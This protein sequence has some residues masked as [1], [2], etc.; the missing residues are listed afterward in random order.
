M[1]DD[2]ELRAARYD[3][4]R[5]HLVSLYQDAMGAYLDRFS[6]A[7]ERTTSG[8]YGLADLGD[9]IRAVWSRAAHDSVQA[10]RLASGLAPA[11][12]SPTL[13]SATI[14]LGSQTSPPIIFAGASEHD[15]TLCLDHLHIL[16]GDENNIATVLGP[17]NFKFTPTKLAGR[18]PA[19]EVVLKIV[20]LNQYDGDEVDPATHLPVGRYIGFVFGEPP[21]N[22]LISVLL[23]I[24][25]PTRAPQVSMT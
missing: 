25:R 23:L 11:I 18:A 12:D 17:H 14:D 2:D 16:D 19:V 8:S 10:M 22:E 21:S 5:D 15:V 9:D 20:G 1:T 24:V 6:N 13:V 7:L 4:R 3:Y